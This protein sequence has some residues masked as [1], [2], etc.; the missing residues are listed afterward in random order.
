M[1]PVRIIELGRTECDGTNGVTKGS[2]HKE[3]SMKMAKRTTICAVI[4]T[5]KGYGQHLPRI[6]LRSSGLRALRFREQLP[7]LSLR[8]NGSRE[9]APDGSQ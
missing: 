2:H 1:M 3:G 4:D 7:R 8:A 6:S 9:C 5:G